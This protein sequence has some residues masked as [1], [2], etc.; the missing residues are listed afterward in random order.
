MLIC[1]DTFKFFIGNSGACYCIDTF[2][3]T[4]GRIMEGNNILIFLLSFNLATNVHS[5]QNRANRASRQKEGDSTE[6]DAVNNNS[7]NQSG[8]RACTALRPK[9]R[10]RKTSPACEK[11]GYPCRTPRSPVI[12]PCSRPVYLT[13]CIPLRTLAL[14]AGAVDGASALSYISRCA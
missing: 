2:V 10:R 4:S 6:N 8:S 7:S 3:N 11:F 1:H 14:Y 9:K 12:S 5:F 13:A